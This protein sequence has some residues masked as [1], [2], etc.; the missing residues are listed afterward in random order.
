M[1]VDGALLAEAVRAVERLVLE[2]GVPPR[3]DENDVVAARQV[4]AR[5]ARLERDEDDLRPA[6]VADLLDRRVALRLLHRPVVCHGSR[7]VSTA[8]FRIPQ[9]TRDESEKRTYSGRT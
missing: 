4:Q 6:A 9:E 5:A 3:V 7:S 2:R 1:D 8:S